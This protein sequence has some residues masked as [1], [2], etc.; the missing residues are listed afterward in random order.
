ML[1]AEIESMEAQQSLDELPSQ[2]IKQANKK[3]TKKEKDLLPKKKSQRYNK[4]SLFVQIINQYYNT[5]SGMSP[6]FLR[7]S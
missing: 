4:C 2:D 3:R 5:F 6:Q 1:T 7:S